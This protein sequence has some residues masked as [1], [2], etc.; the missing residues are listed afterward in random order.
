MQP[1]VPATPT[2]AAPEP[3][4]AAESGGV[5]RMAFVGAVEVDPAKV[6][7]ASPSSV[8]LVDL[9][10][11]GVTAYDPARGTVR[12]ALATSWY[13]SADG[14][15]WRFEIDPQARFADGTPVQP[16]DV[17]ATIE[18]VAGLGDAVLSGNRLQTIAGHADF[19]SRNAT[20]IVGLVATGSTLEVRLRTAFASLPELFADPAF[21]VLK[22]SEA[23]GGL[24][25][26]P[27]GSGPFVLRER[28][29]TS[30]SLVRRA[31]GVAKLAA[32]EVRVY[33]DVAGAWGGFERDEVDQTPMPVEKATGDLPARARVVQMPYQLDVRYGM[34]V[35]APALADLRVR[36]AVVSAVDRDALLS[37]FFPSAL[38]LRGLIGP[39]VPGSRSDACAAACT[40]DAAAARALV[41]EV[42]PDGGAPMLHVDF[43]AEPTGREAA[44]ASAVAASLQAVG[45]PAEA[46]S[47]T[48]EGF[49]QLLVSGGAEV[50]RY[51]WVGSFPSA[52]AYLGPFE[53]NGSDNVF[54]LADD[55]VGALLASARAATSEE[56]RVAAY[57]AAEDRILALA[58]VLPLVRYQTRIAVRDTVQ[59]VL[60]GPDGAIDIA[61]VT[62]DP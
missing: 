61:R 12:G 52:D 34:N 60:L 39:G 6:N 50:F 38:S 3:W 30:M 47:H 17:K 56:A 33:P 16:A 42:Y 28:T 45:L 55:Q 10:Y 18:R 48:L 20:E 37:R 19:V 24:G 43:F 22:A 32:I 26:V 57:L 13:V 44:L 7:P 58:P 25:P 23:R 46:R 15:T 8:Q 5:L 4:A 49:Q 27:T 41:A 36:R 9:L 2:S 35:T 31:R 54:S 59:Q 53:P 14:L 1:P 62:V 40:F 29:A 21:G 11:D 51:G